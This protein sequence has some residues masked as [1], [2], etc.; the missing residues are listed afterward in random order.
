[1]KNPHLP[2]PFF[3]L[4]KSHV[5]RISFHNGLPDRGLKLNRV[6][7]TFYFYAFAC[8]VVGIIRIKLLREPNPGLCSRQRQ[9]N[10]LKQRHTQH[11]PY[12]T[13]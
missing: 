8:V 13:K 2:R 1:M 3:V 11:S 7:R 12:P 6:D 10:I 5:Q 4:F 9:A